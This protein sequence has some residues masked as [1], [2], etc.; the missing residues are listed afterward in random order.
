VHVLV[1][2]AALRLGN[3][4]DCVLTLGDMALVAFHFGVAAFER[5]H[6][7]GMFLGAKRGG[8]E[9]IHGMTDGAI[10]VAGAR[11]ELATVVIRMA[12]GARR[13]CHRRLEITAGV[14]FATGYAAVFS[15]KWER[16]LGVVKAFE[17]GHSRPVRCVVARLA[18][19]FKAALVRIRV[20]ASACGEGE[21]GIFDVRFGISHRSVAFRAGHRRVRSRQRELRSSV[22]ESGSRLPRIRGVALCAVRA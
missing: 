5:I 22:F 9:S 8:L 2:T 7:R 13:M 20:A 4:K 14:A 11:E 21:T 16:R 6:R 3:P 18:G 1:A 17:L 12:I 15:E 19:A 10:F